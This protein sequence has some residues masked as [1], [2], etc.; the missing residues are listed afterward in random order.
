MNNIHFGK[1]VK[2]VIANTKNIEVLAMH[3]CCLGYMFKMPL[4]IIW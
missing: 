2:L 3:G 1:N 4:S